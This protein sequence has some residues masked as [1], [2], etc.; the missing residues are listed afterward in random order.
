MLRIIFD[1]LGFLIV[2]PKLPNHYYENNWV[3]FIFDLH[4]NVGIM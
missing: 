4:N 2:Y 1:R 3:F